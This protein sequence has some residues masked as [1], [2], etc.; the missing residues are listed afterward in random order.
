MN[1]F[2]TEKQHILIVDDELVNLK[3][4]ST[5]LS[6][7]GY[8][9]TAIDNGN[10]A[11][12]IVKKDKPNLILLDIK[13]PDM[14]GYE[15]CR[16]IKSDEFSSNIPVIFLS[17]LSAT[18]D[19]VKG[20]S[21]GGTD[22]ITKPFQKNEI[23]ARV[24]THLQLGN[25]QKKL[26][27]SE[28][29]F[30]RIFE[31]S[32]IGAA[33][34]SLENEFLQVNDEFCRFIGYNKE[35]LLT[36][37]V[38]D[39]TYPGDIHDIHKLKQYMNGEIEHYSIDKRYVRKNNEVVWGH[40]SIRLIRDEYNN[41]MYSLPLIEDI[42]ER[43]KAEKSLQESNEKL[44]SRVD[45]LSLLNSITKTM[46]RVNNIKQ[47]LTITIKK[48]GTLLNAHGG[49]FILFDE[50]KKQMEI[51]AHYVSDN[52]G[53]DLTG[54]IVPDISGQ[55]RLL[56]N[57]ESLVF[58]D[59]RSAPMLAPVKD[60]IIARDIH[61]MMVIPLQLPEKILGAIVL[62]SNIPGRE[63]ASDEIKL[64]ETVAGQV[65]GP[66]EN[67]RL[68]FKTQQASR[69]KSEFMARMSHELRTPMN[70]VLGFTHLVQQTELD[71]KQINFVKKIDISAK[72]LQRLIN[73]ILDFSNID[74][75]KTKLK[76][77]LFNMEDVLK[78]LYNYLSSGINNK[79]IDIHFSLSNDIPCFMKGDLARLEQILYSLAENAVKYTEYGSISFS[80]KCNFI[81]S[82]K[83]KL[84][85]T[86]SDTGIGISYDKIP[87]L[88]DMFYQGDNPLT[89]KHGGTGLGL[90][91]CKRL[92]EMMDGEINVESSPDQGTE[93]TFSLIF[94]YGEDN[95]KIS[96][97]IFQNNLIPGQ[98]VKK[99]IDTG[100]CKEP[101]HDELDIPKVTPF[102][103]KFAQLLDENDMEA[104]EHLEY[105]KKLTPC[106]HPL[107]EDLEIIEDYLDLYEFEQAYERLEGILNKLNISI[108]PEAGI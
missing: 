65:S 27:E 57:G 6:I 19:K 28:Q 33:I 67:S 102:L 42:S 98:P 66:I 53:T 55:S 23:I 83:I 39:I 48:I 93:F 3:I 43:K 29:K 38:Q 2:L 73:N 30:R 40:V 72:S 61:A 104:V 62:S 95:R 16:K 106:S 90:A 5:I 91:F 82:K 26:E 89:R 51:I 58:A 22:Y 56:E 7:T 12:D 69:A 103:I 105:L 100:I 44:Q 15:V 8:K 20:F 32:P 41:P 108:I 18:H 36:L 92:I 64:V 47:A 24:K 107:G 68:Y 50:E 13:M 84:I 80:L 78:N 31:Q 59:A 87:N 97:D 86:L 76:S 54:I 75:G 21:A 99:K 77:V 101:G 70:A 96:P 9:V 25:M 49:S 63:F 46:T 34:V 79:K 11:L 60:L 52:K 35:E 4:L 88:F 71:S 85:F 14:D 45:E 17:G 74:S 10:D 94:A 37:K 1:T 81:M